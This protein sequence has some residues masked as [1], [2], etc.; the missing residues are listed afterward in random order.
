MSE[1]AGCGRDGREDR[2]GFTEGWEVR[3]FV[4]CGRDDRE[5]R[6]GGV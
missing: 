3:E 4:R 5:D 1:K 2:L 6:L